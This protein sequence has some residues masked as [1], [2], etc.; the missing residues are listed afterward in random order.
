LTPALALERNL[1]VFAEF[2]R[3]RRRIEA[4][5]HDG[6]QQDLAATAVGLQL[7][8]LALDANDPAAAR[9]LLEELEDDVEE[10]L[11]RL[12]ALALTIYPSG[13][14]TR[15]LAGA[16][17]GRADLG[18]LGRYPLEVEEAV[19]FACHELLTETTRARVWEED[20]AVRLEVSGAADPAA[21]AHVRA[22]LAAV[23]GQVTVSSGGAAVA[24]A[25]P[26]SSAR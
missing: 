10:A 4:A 20:G 19:Y 13:L 6:L 17:A 12:R 5:L 14:P 22:R 24:A 26:I 2:D 8:V 3:E 11:A 15:G 25:V 9:K 18:P 16:L 7:V 23:G 1:L 21:V